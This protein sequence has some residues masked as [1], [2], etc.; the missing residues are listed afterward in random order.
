MNPDGTGFEAEVAEAKV[1][2]ASPQNPDGTGFEAELAREKAEKEK[3][4]AVTGIMAAPL[5]KA[6]TAEQE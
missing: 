1:K 5:T 6:D 4:M 3:V 2:S